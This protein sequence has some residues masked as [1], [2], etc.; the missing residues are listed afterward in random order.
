MIQKSSLYYFGLFA[1]TGVFAGCDNKQEINF[2][3][4]M[5]ALVAVGYKGYV[6]HEFI[7]TRDA[8]QGLREAV[9]L[10]DV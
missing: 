7:P 3:P 9:T 2:P 8:L 4:I 6:G 10:C 1:L 5:E